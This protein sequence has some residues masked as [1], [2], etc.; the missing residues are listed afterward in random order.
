ML[1]SNQVTPLAGQRQTQANPGSSLETPGGVFNSRTIELG[2]ILGAS[3]IYYFHIGLSGHYPLSSYGE[4]AVE[5]FVILA[6]IAYVLFSTSKPSVPSEY[7]DYLKRRLAALF[8]MFLLVNLAIYLGNFLYP[9]SL[10]RPY[11]FIEFLASAAGVSQ[12]FGWKYMSAVMW[13]MPFIMQAYLLFPLIDWT[14]RQVNAVV[15]VLIAFGLSY[16]LVQTVPL[17][18]KS[19]FQAQLVCKNWSP[20][21]RLPEV[22]VGIILGRIALTRR[23]HGVGILAVAVYGIL[24]LLVS[25]LPPTNKPPL[26]YMPWGGFVVPAVLFGASVLLS[27]L[28]RATN[29]NLVRMLGFSSYSFYLLHAAP[30]VAISRHFHNQAIVWLAY[31]LACWVLAFTLTR[32]L[33][34]AKNLLAGGLCRQNN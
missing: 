5:Y 15:L 1:D 31:F 19:D 26:F 29:A 30:L 34:Q 14:A 4:F 2:R 13:F 18:V 33:A 20:V 12:Y 21:L 9:S 24:S 7:F 23:G 17:F 3:T 27:P 10:G 25:L 22:C 8:P 32:L 28:L 16:L 6:G 11:R